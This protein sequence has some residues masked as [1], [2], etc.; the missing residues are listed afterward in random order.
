MIR[1]KETYKQVGEQYGLTRQAVHQIFK[2]VNQWFVPQ[3]LDD[4]KS[5]KARQ[6]AHLRNI[7]IEA[8]RAWEDSKRPTKTR[9]RGVAGEN[10][11][12]TIEHRTS[13]G[14]PA[15]LRAALDALADI[16]KVIGADAPLEVRHTGEV[17]VAG[18]T[19]DDI[20]AEAFENIRALIPKN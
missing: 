16:R 8:M 13:S 10:A 11:I 20:K 4:I 15:F 5:E 14:N 7:F 6:V 1:G 9:K 18:K 19:I 2:K 3:I 12:D 17:R